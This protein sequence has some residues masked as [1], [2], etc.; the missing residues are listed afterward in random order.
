M[1]LSRLVRWQVIERVKRKASFYGQDPGAVEETY[2][3]PPETV[4]HLYEQSVMPLTK[5]VQVAYLL[6]RLEHPD[7]H[8]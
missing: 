5:E 3:V 2:K 8:S 1:E 7:H 6:R 4:A